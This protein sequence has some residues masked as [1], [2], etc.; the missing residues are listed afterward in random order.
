MTKSHG[1]KPPGQEDEFEADGIEST[2]PNRLKDMR[3]GLKSKYPDVAP[4][5][6][7]TPRREKVA[8]VASYTPKKGGNKIEEND[9]EKYNDTVQS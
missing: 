3:K 6:K 5:E 4:G 9:P 2:I 7:W 1:G 8:M